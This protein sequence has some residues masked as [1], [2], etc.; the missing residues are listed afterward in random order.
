MFQKERQLSVL[1]RYLFMGLEGQESEDLSMARSVGL[2][3]G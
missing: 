2:P 3:G 1:H